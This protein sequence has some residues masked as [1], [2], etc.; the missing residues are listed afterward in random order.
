MSLALLP[1]VKDPKPKLHDARDSTAGR[2]ENPEP[3]A[4]KKRN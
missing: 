1:F 2:P 3:K 4:A